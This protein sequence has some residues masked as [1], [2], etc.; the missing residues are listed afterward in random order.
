MAS[1]RI[2]Y[3]KEYNRFRYV[4]EGV[5]KF[6]DGIYKSPG[7]F[8]TRDEA[9]VRAKQALQEETGVDNGW[10]PATVAT[11]PTEEEL[12]S[13]CGAV[14]DDDNPLMIELGE[15]EMYPWDDPDADCQSCATSKAD[16]AHD[17]MME[18]E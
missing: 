17:R 5:D 6:T 7:I 4:L 9:V 14:V 16:A 2:E 8:G 3:H 1:W 12:C 15:E 18:G 11:Q 10:R 13:H